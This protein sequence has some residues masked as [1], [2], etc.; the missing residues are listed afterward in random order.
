[1]QRAVRSL[2]IPQAVKGPTRSYAGQIYFLPALSSPRAT[3]FFPAHA[4][5]VARGKGEP[6]PRA[7]RFSLVARPLNLGPERRG[8][9][10]RR[11]GERGCRDDAEE[12]PQAPRARADGEDRRAVRRRAAAGEGEGGAGA[13]GRLLPA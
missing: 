2:S 9:G 1:M 10:A 3:P 7:G 12:R 5:D 6:S 4:R 11:A 13:G 8:M